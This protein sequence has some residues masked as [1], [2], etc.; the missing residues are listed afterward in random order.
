M[1]YHRKAFTLLE[2][3]ISIMLLS[4]VLMALYRSTDILRA[5][6]K[7]LFHHLEHSSDTMKGVNALYMDL[8]E[9]DGNITI[10]KD[11]KLHKIIISK[12]FHSLYGLYHTKVVWLVYKENNSL[13]R[14]ESGENF[15]LPIKSE[16][17][18]AIDT[19]SKNIELFK[20][21]INKN[22]N[23]IIILI[24]IKGEEAHSFMIQNLERINLKKRVKLRNVNR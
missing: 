8:I 4:L 15:I 14:I 18:I 16:N 1:I 21:Y 13:L 3:L 5:S 22:N 23:K 7:N 2:V 20:A 11:K 12:T 19:I 9:S 10:N 6:N 24:K 17:N